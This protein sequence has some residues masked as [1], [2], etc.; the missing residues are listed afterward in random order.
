MY[1]VKNILLQGSEARESYFETFWSQRDREKRR[2]IP[3]GSHAPK[4]W[5]DPK[6]KDELK[7]EDNLI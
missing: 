2:A 7:K 5:D 6:H 4:N 3:I 1:L